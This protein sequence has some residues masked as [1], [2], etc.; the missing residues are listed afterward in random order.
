[1]VATVGAAVKVRGYNLATAGLVAFLGLLLLTVVDIRRGFLFALTEY[2]KI[3]SPSVL[4]YFDPRH[5]ALLAAAVAGMAL[6]YRH[7][8][9]A[10]AVLKSQG[11][12]LRTQAKLLAIALG[13]LL[14]VDLFIYRGV[15][16]TRIVASGKLGIGQAIPLASFAG[17]LRPLGDAINYMLLV[18]HA[19]LLA[20]VIGGLFLAVSPAFVKRL[21]GTGFRA[22]LAGAAMAVPQ[23]FC[24]CCAAPI[25]SSL[26][27][28]GATLGPVLA[29]TVS[30][31]MLNLSTWILASALLPTK[32]A[33]LRIGGGLVIG[34]L[35]TYV[36]SLVAGRWVAK[37]VVQAKPGLLFDV[38]GRLVAAFSRLFQFESSLRPDSVGMDSPTALLSRWPRLVWKLA[39]VVVPVLFVGALIA[40]AVV[41]GVPA[42]ANNLATVGVVAALG[43]LLMVPTWTEIPIAAGLI[44]EGVSGPAAALLLTLPAV[45]VPCLIVLAGAMRS[46][47]VALVLGLLVFAVGLGVGAAFVYL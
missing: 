27:R 37:P 46:F 6:A 22:H 42:S 40:A 10:E 12:D 45:S 43:T 47:R 7:M 36:A 26:Y 18:W 14:V 24:S 20:L 9:R 38:S 15:P 4:V 1:M 23:P 8:H 13:A 17:W 33:L 31:P 39:K 34:V 28:A 25:G 44:K 11:A 19:T 41:S 29:F 21:R 35:L 2:H 3:G 30:A 32:Y 5:V 16:A